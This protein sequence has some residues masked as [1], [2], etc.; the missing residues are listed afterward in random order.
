MI[1]AL[2]QFLSTVVLFILLSQSVR[3]FYVDSWGTA[4]LAA[5]VFGFVNATLGTIL[6][7]LSFPLILLTLGLFY[8]VVNAFVLLVVSFLLG[9][10]FQING[11]WPALVAAVA[12]AALGLLWKVVPRR[13]AGCDDD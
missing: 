11:W 1:R 8:F 4:V 12:L 5:L 2:L 3:G 6:R 7:V 10:A 13:R 9:Q